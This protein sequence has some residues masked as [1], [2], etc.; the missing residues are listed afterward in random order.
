[1]MLN[2]LFLQTRAD[3]GLVYGKPAG[4]SDWQVHVCVTYNPNIHMLPTQQ[5]YAVSV[6]RA[7]ECCIY[8]VICPLEQV[9]KIN[10]NA[11]FIKCCQIYHYQFVLL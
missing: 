11:K 10:K 2:N 9:N 7:S 1:M 4:E 3:Y 6:V 5:D 8:Y